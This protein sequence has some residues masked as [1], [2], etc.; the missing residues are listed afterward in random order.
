MFTLQVDFLVI[1]T[2]QS[3][4]SYPLFVLQEYPDDDRLKTAFGGALDWQKIFLYYVRSAQNSV[5]RFGSRNT[6]MGSVSRNRFREWALQTCSSEET[7]SAAA[8][9]CLHGV[10]DYQ[11]FNSLSGLPSKYLANCE[12]FND[13][14]C[15]GIVHFLLAF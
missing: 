11:I 3:R 12:S 1:W 15:I 14:F 6:T 7:A 10:V 2:S 13:Q 8:V 9:L 4:L 5:S